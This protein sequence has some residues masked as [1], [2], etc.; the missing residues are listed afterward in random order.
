MVMDETMQRFCY[1]NAGQEACARTVD[2]YQETRR[3]NDN[4]RVNPLSPVNFV[5]DAGIARNPGDQNMRAL[6]QTNRYPLAGNPV[7]Q[8]LTNGQTTNA[9]VDATGRVGRTN[10]FASLNQLLAG[11]LG[12]VPRG[13]HAQQRAPEPRPPVRHRRGPA[14]PHGLQRSHGQQHRL[15]SGSA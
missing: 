7:R 15:L 11:G 3:I 13:V 8:V 14:V 5:N 1:L 6:Y 2:I 12:E 10:F 4:N 9:T